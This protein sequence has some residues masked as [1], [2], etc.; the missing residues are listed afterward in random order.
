MSYKGG[1]LYLIG[2]V[3]LRTGEDLE[4]YKIGIVRDKENRSTEERLKEH[5][6]GNPRMLKTHWVVRTPMVEMIETTL[7]GRF[8][9]WR[10]SGEWFHLDDPR[11]KTVHRTTTSLATQ[12]AEKETSLVVAED[13][14]KIVSK[15]AVMSPQ[16]E[17]SNLH[18]RLGALKAN[19]SAADEGEKKLKKFFDSLHANGQDV[20]AY[21]SLIPRAGTIEFDEDDFKAQYPDLWSRYQ[22]TKSAPDPRFTIA[23]LSAFKKDESLLQ[24]DLVLLLEEIDHSI[25]DEKSSTDL[26]RVHGLYLEV[27]TFKLPLA[28]E[29]S[30]AEAD[31][32]VACG[33]AS[34]IEGVCTWNRKLKETISFDKTAFKDDHPELLEQF[35]SRKPDTVSTALRKDRNYRV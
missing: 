35:S 24:P 5:Q 20:S 18:K 4:F 27:L 31:L 25:Q 14:K 6:T 22:V 34:G 30:L 10:I 32:K 17:T 19:H 29:V 16:E 23:D 9:P 13:L 33:D 11:V 2:E 28:W 3:D 7:H 1:E 15:E 12:A 8:A 26:D 21:F